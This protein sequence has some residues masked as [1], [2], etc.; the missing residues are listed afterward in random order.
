MKAALYGKKTGNFSGKGAKTACIF[1]IRT[2]KNAKECGKILT[3]G[4]LPAPRIAAHLLQLLFGAP[5]QQLLRLFRG[6]VALGDVAGAAGVDDVGDGDTVG[7]LEGVDDVQ[8]AVSVARAKVEHLRAGVG[9]G[10]AQGG[11][12]AAGQ[13][14]HVD[15]I[16]D[17]GAVGGGIVIA[18]NMELLQPPGGHAGHVGQQV[19]GNALGQLTDEAGGVGADGVE[20]AQQHHR[21]LRVGGGLIPEDLLDHVFR[22]AV[23]V[24]AAGGHILGEGDGLRHAVDRG[25]GAEHDGVHMVIGH[26]LQQRQ[27]G[28][29]VVAVVFQRLFHRLTHGLEAGEV[30]D[31]LEIVLLEHLL[32][33]GPVGHVNLVKGRG[34][35]CDASDARYHVFGAVAQIVGDDHVIPRLEQLH[36]RVRADEA[37]AAGE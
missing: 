35:A 4:R 14:H 5:A 2:W 6:G 18:E 27:R 24:G 25:G 9:G 16:P 10:V 36:C 31:G 21:Q 37:R 13:V 20:V 3:K 1:R 29:Q 22:P 11:Q 23:G 34:A 26:G 32:Q 30:D 8:H 19:V 7:G 15:V 17:A 12:V 28:V 33:S